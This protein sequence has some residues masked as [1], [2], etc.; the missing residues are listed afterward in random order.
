MPGIKPKVLILSLTYFPHIGGAEVAVR[1]ITDRLS[2]DYSFDLVCA[3]LDKKLAKT[4]KIGEMNVYRMGF[5]YQVLDKAIFTFFGFGK[6]LRL[7]WKNKYKIVWPIMAAY[8]S[9]AFLFKI[10]T[11]VKVILT[12]QEGDA[13]EYITGLKRFRF[14]GWAY[15]I[16]FKLVDKVQVIS[17][18]L[19]EW[20]KELGVKENKIVLVPNGVDLEKFSDI[21]KEK[22]AEEEKIILT[23]S[24]LVE[25]NG[26]EYVIRAM[27]FLNNIKLVIVGDGVLRKELKNLAR[28]KNVTDR[29][30]FIGRVDFEKIYEYYAE[31]DV[32]VRSSLSEGFGN[33]FIQA[34]AAEIPVIAT[35]VG[36]I[37]DFLVDGETGWFCKVKDP[38]SIAEKIKYVLG[39]QN[40]DE[41]A[42]VVK[43]AREMVEEKYTWEK[44]A[45]EMK[46]VFGKLI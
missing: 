31:A 24:R 18:F 13:L 10:F 9:F 7:H 44:V 29:V 11:R 21:K 15:K 19:A 40:K 2:G 41:V 12:L 1:E 30:E 35:P 43:N 3:R 27:E 4:E 14:F 42:Q 28:E 23:D 34:M 33:V 32:F 46:K 8:A 22:S 36:G 45:S 38:E 16:Y 6:S 20:A 25:K 17:N 39:E 26:V 5:G 37:P